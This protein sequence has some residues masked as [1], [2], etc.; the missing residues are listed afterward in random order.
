MWVL[1]VTELRDF[2]ER[3]LQEAGKNLPSGGACEIAADGR[4]VGCGSCEGLDRQLR[5]KLRGSGPP[6]LEGGYEPGIVRGLGDYRHVPVILG[7]GSNH[8]GAADVDH[9]DDLFPGG[10]RASRGGLEGVEVDDQQLDGLDPQIPQ[11]RQVLRPVPAGQQRR[12]N[13]RVQGLDSSVEHLREAR[14]LGNLRHGKS[15]LQKS[16]GGAPGGEER[17]PALHESP[18]QIHDTRLVVNAQECQAPI[19]SCHL[20]C[21]W[22]LSWMG[23]PSTGRPQERGL[24]GRHPRLVA[25]RA[26]RGARCR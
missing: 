22:L 14:V 3:Q 19:G 16:P 15:G 25:K 7:G 21:S 17:E 5:T 18:G 13:L 11:C 1:T 4:V 6:L 12:V 9:F 10:S 2:F 24:P 26:P 20:F 8:G 23:G